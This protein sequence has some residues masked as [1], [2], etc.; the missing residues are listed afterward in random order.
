MIARQ[1]SVPNLIG[2]KVIVIS[3]VLAG[4]LVQRVCRRACPELA[5]GPAESGV[6]V[7]GSDPYPATSSGSRRAP[8]PRRTPRLTRAPFAST[9]PS[10]T[11]SSPIQTSAP[12]MLSR[13]T[14]PA[15]ILALLQTT[16][17]STRPR[18]RTSQPSPITV[19]P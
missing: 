7:I 12:M 16:E 14:A 17:C 3:V 2:V 15:P 18:S 10:T 4:A 8:G 11:A 6:Q 13:T 9:A 5:E 1:P 19:G